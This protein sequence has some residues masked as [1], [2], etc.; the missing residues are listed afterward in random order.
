MGDNQTI[1]LLF[2]LL[3]IFVLLRMPI[4][5]SL[6][7]IAF[8]GI[9][10]VL[11]WRVAWGTLGTVPYQFAASW[12]LS[13]VP[14][15]LFMGFIC[16]HGRLTQGLFE[17]GRVWLSALPGGLAVASVFGCAGFAA[18]T[19]SSLA[20]SAAMGKVAVPEMTKNNYDI[21]LATGTVAAAGTIGALIPPSILL[22]IYGIIAQVSI[23]GL[24]LG[25]I[26]AGL[27]TAFAYVMVIIIRVKLNPALAPSVHDSIQPG[28]RWRALYNTWPVI[29]IVLGVFGG[30]FSGVFTPT[31]AG[32]I[33][34]LP[35]LPGEL[36]QRHA[37][38]VGPASLGA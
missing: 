25:G 9:W 8:V 34:G 35:V 14:T 21:E 20:C 24:F 4:G 10:E 38:P 30:L 18:V 22:I 17:A 31:E 5:V 13:S 2:G 19:G 7:G 33:G 26:V 32:A 11:G 16:Y 6:I 23:N 37:D 3:L 1:L 29:L 15:F 12:V 27:L 36:V 28:E